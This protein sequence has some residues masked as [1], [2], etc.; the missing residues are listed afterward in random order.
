MGEREKEGGLGRSKPCR[1]RVSKMA[2]GLHK[3]QDA[4]L[5]A[6]RLPLS[7]YTGADSRAKETGAALG[8]SI[9]GG[10]RAEVVRRAE[11]STGARCK[12]SATGPLPR[13]SPGIFRLAL[14]P[15]VAN[16]K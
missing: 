3:Q 9:G 15:L 14:P 6:S 5:Y 10:W 11:A 7:F 16:L 12:G 1:R 4:L 8:N 2:L 13:P